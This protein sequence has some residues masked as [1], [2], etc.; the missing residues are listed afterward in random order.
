MDILYACT[1]Y[2]PAIGGAQIHL[3]CLARQM[4]AMGNNVRVYASA[5]R[6]RTDWLPLS[7]F[8]PEP[9]QE[10]VHEGVPVTQVGYGLSTRLR[11]LPWALSYY[12]LMEPAVHRI[13]KLVGDQIPWPDRRPSV[14]HVSRIGREFMAQAALDYARR[15]RVPFVLTPNHHPRWRGYL[16]RSYDRIYREAD[17]IFALTNAEKESL[18]VEKGIP[19][20]RV[21][22]TGIGPVLSDAYSAENFRQRHG[23]EGKFVLYL[24]QQLKY[25]G[26]GSL[27]EAAPLIW[28]KHP[29]ARI[30]F[31]G[32]PSAYSQR[33]FAGVSDPRLIN[34][35]SVD[36]ETKTSALAACE[37]LCLPS[38]QESFGGVFVEAWAMRKPVIGGRIPPIANVIDDGING[39]LSMQEPEELAAA[40]NM[41]LA[42]DSRRIAMGQAGWEKVQAKYSW[43]QIGRQTMAVYESVGESAYSRPRVK[44]PVLASSVAHRSEMAGKVWRHSTRRMA[45]PAKSSEHRPLKILLSHNY[46][47]QPGGEDLSFADEANLLESRG[48]DVIRYTMHNDSIDAMGSIGASQ[49]AVWNEDAYR[50]V[51]E[52]IHQDRPDVVHCTNT[53]PLISPAVY[54]AARRAGVPVVQSL[55]NYRT[56][57]L[58]ATLLRDGKVCEDCL[59]HSIPWPGVMHGCYRGN[60]AAS[61]VVATMSGI[62]RAMRTWT[63]TVNYYYTLTEFSRRKFIEGG[64]PASR[65]AIKQN[66]VHPDPRAGRGDGGYVVFAGRLSPEKGID[67]MLAAWSRMKDA[68]VLKIVGDGPESDL[69]KKAAAANPRIQ[70]IGFRPLD[71]VLEIIGGASCLVIPSIWYETFGR[72]IIEA[73]AK[74]TPVIASRLGAMAELVANGRTGLHFEPGNPA[75]LGEKVRQFLSDPEQMAR[76]RQAAR[77]E[78]ETKYTAEINYR[79][80][81]SIYDRTLHRVTV[82][83]VGVN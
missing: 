38:M 67:T 32:P 60:R 58:N 22:V 10:R 6:N 54:Y 1:L 37:L 35:G 82:P 18:V 42:D 59:G 27:V 77:A 64:F 48:H 49:R 39:L 73:F 19:A 14:V 21:H 28:K 65:I 20:E 68:P 25:K 2:P 11:V 83:L 17:A 44:L 8:R 76:M 61:A 4:Q 12:A 57:C 75:D 79:S 46:Y 9:R 52:I 7:T 15:R 45:T 29:D 40:V 63:R 81:M 47:K 51:T 26:I 53:F 72:T 41:M 80:L 36:L 56:L 50:R 43:E 34:L 16:Y 13:G 74:G 30:V 69:V 33:I 78:Y 71:E 70:W 23:I 62:H 24:G 31:I 5:L 3:H 55:R 66:F